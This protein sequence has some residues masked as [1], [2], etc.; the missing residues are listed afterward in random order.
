M[1]KCK[2]TVRFETG[3]TGRTEQ[4]AYR[5]LA[6]DIT[7]GVCESPCGAGVLSACAAVGIRGTEVQLLFTDDA[8]IQELNRQYRSLDRSTDVLSFPLNDFAYGEGR[9]QPW[10]ADADSGFLSLGDIVI[11]VPTLKRQAAEYGHSE[12]RECAFLICHGMLHLLGY[13]H[14]NARDEQQMT[15]L[16]EEILTRKGYER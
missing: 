1:E 9:V 5:K 13:D 4:K 16:A 15:A 10:D 2:C 12:S 14:M 8:S 6:A 7:A 11:S 3:I